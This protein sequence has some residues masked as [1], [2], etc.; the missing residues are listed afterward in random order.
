MDC[1]HFRHSVVFHRKGLK[2]LWTTG[3]SFAEGLELLHLSEFKSAPCSL[4][5]TKDQ[6]QSL[7]HATEIPHPW[8][9]F[10]LNY[11]FQLPRFL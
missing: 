10:S 1:L 8:A 3:V 7:A 2:W 11:N 6:I 9:A 4:F 5:S